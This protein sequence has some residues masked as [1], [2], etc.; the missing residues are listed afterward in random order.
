MAHDFAKQHSSSEALRNRR[1]NNKASATK[2]SQSNTHWPWFFSGLLSGVFATFLFFYGLLQPAFLQDSNPPVNLQA[3]SPNSTLPEE[4]A[5]FTFYDRLSE[6]EVMVD[7]VAVELQPQAEDD[8]AI[9]RV[10]AASFNTRQ[11][12]ENLRAEILIL[13][14]DASIYEAEVL[15]QTRYRVQAGP[16]TGNNNAEDAIDLLANNNIIGAIKIRVQ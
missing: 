9:Y 3:D 15:G 10:Q 14:M 5:E 2:V 12:A 13:G 11:D 4:G 7:V 1:N 6:A 16:F 8:L